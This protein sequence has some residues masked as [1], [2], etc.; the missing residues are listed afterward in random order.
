LPP[1]QRRKRILEK[2]NSINDQIKQET[3]VRDA[4]I[5]M[6]A[7]YQENPAL[8]DPNTIDSQLTESSKKMDK[9]QSELKKFECYLNEIE[10]KKSNSTIG[11][12]GTVSELNSS[13]MSNETRNSTSSAASAVTLNNGRKNRNSLSEES[14]SRSASDSSVSQN[15][16]Q[17]AATLPTLNGHDSSR[18]STTSNTPESNRMPHLSPSSIK[19]SD[20]HFSSASSNTESITDRDER[21]ACSLEKE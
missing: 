3:N 20:N 10:V 15:H 1:V 2:I 13:Q 6:K 7:A 14:L 11:R 17:S 5:K 18:L 8:G 4:L 16:T 9:L 21:D 12:N 19:N